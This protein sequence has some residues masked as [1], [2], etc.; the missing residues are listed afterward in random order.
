MSAAV[1][2][3][4]FGHKL[5]IIKE[6]GFLRP[7]GVNISPRE[8]P[9]L[10]FSRNPQFEQTAAKAW[11]QNGMVTLMTHSEMDRMLGIFR[12]KLI[13]PDARLYS[14]MQLQRKARI[15]PKTICHMIDEGVKRGARPRDWYG[16]FVPIPLGSMR[17]QRWNDPAQEWEFVP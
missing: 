11:L 2:H 7:T 6:D 3:Y 14:W 17:L 1:Y 9:V 4:T 13:T 15:P 10:W 5:R 8:V 16:S 12:F